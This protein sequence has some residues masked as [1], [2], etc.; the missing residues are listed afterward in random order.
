MGANLIVGKTQVEAPQT[1]MAQNK[2]TKGGASSN[3]NV[4]YTVQQGDTLWKIAQKYS[5]V[6]VDDLI[7]LNNF[8]NEDKITP[9]QKIKVQ[10]AS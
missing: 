4:Y 2:S 7:R 10:S 1:E 9:G 8:R 6:S 5:G 3:N